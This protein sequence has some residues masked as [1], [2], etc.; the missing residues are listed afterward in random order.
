M[1]ARQ[2]AGA[3]L[4]NLLLCKSSIRKAAILLRDCKLCIRNNDLLLL[5][6]F[7]FKLL[8]LFLL[9]AV[10]TV[11]NCYKLTLYFQL[12]ASFLYFFMLFTFPSAST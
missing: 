6:T 7:N 11:K 2:C 1:T 9:L 8:I 4:F 5:E 10:L 3:F 12:K